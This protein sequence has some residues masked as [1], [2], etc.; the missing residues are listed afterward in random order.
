LDKEISGT[1]NRSYLDLLTDDQI[2]SPFENTMLS[3]WHR[4]M[5]HVLNTLTPI[6]QTILRWRFGLDSG[7]EE[8]TLKEIG[9]HYSLSRERI[10]QIQ[11]HALKKIRRK[12]DVS[13][14]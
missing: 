1:D 4:N 5:K 9:A 13:A 8:M 6:E 10:R 7:G 11:E 12:L 2:K 14:A 3:A